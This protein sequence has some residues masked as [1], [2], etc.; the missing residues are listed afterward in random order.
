MTSRYDPAMR[1]ALLTLAAC[2][3]SPLDPSEVARDPAADGPWRTGVTTLTAIDDDGGELTIE[4]WYPA[5]P[6]DVEPEVTLGIPTQSGRDATADLRGGPFPLIAFSHGSGGIRVQSVYLTEHLA[7]W[8][9]VVVAPD[10]PRDVLGSSSDDRPEAFRARPRQVS[11]A[12]DAALA[13]RPELIDG[14]RIGVAG[15]SFGG[16]TALALAG[17]HVDV[18][19]LRAS[20]T[21]DP[22]QLACSGVDDALTQELVDG[23]PDP[24]IAVAVALAP[25]GRIAFGD[26]GLS[27]ITIPTQLQGGTADTLATPAGEIEPMFDAI[28]APRSLGLIERAAHFSFTDICVLFEESGGADGPLAFLATEGCGSETLPIARAHAASRT[29]AA[30]FFD[31]HLRGEPDA[32]YLSRVPDAEVR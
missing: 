27:A 30:A 31:V 16:F 13:A 3:A 14:S 10:H 4:L 32:G 28:A 12:I 24:R 17:G 2:G 5:L 23:F 26:A 22:E 15:H 7:S 19:A 21:A 1:I 8:G 25:A 18:A 29:L 11:R 9:Y 20:C 6:D